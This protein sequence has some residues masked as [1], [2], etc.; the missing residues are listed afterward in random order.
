MIEGPLQVTN[1]TQ[2]QNLLFNRSLDNIVQ[3]W[4]SLGKIF[5]V[6]MLLEDDETSKNRKFCAILRILCLHMWR[7]W[8][9]ER[10]D[11]Y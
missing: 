11:Q 4:F 1:L 3:F 10:P 8:K 2:L 6:C 5:K 7:L 9:R